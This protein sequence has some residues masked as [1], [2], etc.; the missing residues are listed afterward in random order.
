M[1]EID[2]DV[3]CT[4]REGFEPVL[5]ALGIGTFGID[6]ATNVHSIVPAAAKIMLPED[7]LAALWAG[8]LWCNPPYSRPRPWVDRCVAHDATAV[9]L[10]SG[11]FSTRM[12]REVIWPTAQ[13][14]VLLH[15]RLRFFNPATPARKTGAKR[16]NAWVFWRLNLD[17]FDPK[18]LTTVGE[19]VAP[20]GAI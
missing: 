10:I 18:P 12:W 9:A 4:P 6:P 19:L 7:G 17:R 15:R 8:D 16:P 3:E 13:A 14:V 1:G 20:G 2:T 5:A 11:D